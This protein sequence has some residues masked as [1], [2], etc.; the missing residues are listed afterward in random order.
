MPIQGCRVRNGAEYRLV[1]VR[2]F[3][4]TVFRERGWWVVDVPDVAARA[5]AATLGR[6]EDVAE[7]LIAD[8][9]G[10]DAGSFMVEI[11]VVR[12]FAGGVVYATWRTGL[13]RMPLRAQPGRLPMTTTVL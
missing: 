8:T 5:R 10:I 2:F 11:R 12:S 4:A 13:R 9:L 6:V 1:S 3:E 7:A